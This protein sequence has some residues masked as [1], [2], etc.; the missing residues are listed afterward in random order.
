VNFLAPLFLAGAAAVA[1]PFL[2]HLIRRSS[3]EKIVFSSL[4]FLEPSPPRLTK[5]SRL[6]HI[7]LLLLRCAVVTLLALAFARPFF[8]RP[9]AASPAGE[10]STRVAVLVDASG[11]MRREDLWA[12][13]QARARKVVGDLKPSDTFALYSF[14]TQL[15]P[16]LTFAEAGRLNAGE[17]AAA[18]EARL[19]AVQPGWA[20]THLGHALLNAT[21]QLVEQLNRDA[22]DQGNAALRLVVVSDMQ[23]GAR[24]DG[25]QGFEWPKKLEV[26][27]EPLS[28]REL[29]NASLQVLEENQQL[30]SAVTNAPLRV[31]LNNAAQ[32]KMEQFTLHWQ[33]GAET[34]GEPVK[35]YIPPGQNRVLTLAGAPES[36]DSVRLEGD[37]VPFD[38]VEYFARPKVQPLSIA[39]FGSE[40]AEDS[41]EMRYYLHRAFEQTNLSTRVLAFSNTVPAEAARSALLV[42]GAAPTE[43]V[44]QLARRLLDEGRTV[45]LPLRDA[46]EANVISS[47][48]G[49]LLAAATEAQVQNY[50][51]LGQISFHHP[52]FAPFSDARYNDFTKIHFW[53]YRALNLANLTNATV[54]AAFDSGI[55]MLA[56]IP[57]SKGRLLVLGTTWRP[58]DSQLALS[59]KF[60]PLLFGILE[61]SA[62]FRAA[63]HQFTVGERV[64]L[65]PGYTGEI[66]LPEGT[67]KAAQSFFSDTAGPGIYAAGDYRFAVNLSPAES[68]IAPITIDEIKT[69]GVPVHAAADAREMA[70][71]EQRKRRLLATETEARQKM[72]R[73]F[74]LAAIVF[75]LA[76]TWLSGRASRATAPA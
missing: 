70:K 2:F 9:M 36:A 12:Q 65:P 31:R 62:G 74:L 26:Q 69:L 44:R 38:N 48:A 40:S 50:A 27:F 71:E 32:A 72:W 60:I 73:N 68:R 19:K 61:Q 55:P 34:I 33:R 18:A 56:E 67:S 54:I 63:A 6:E 66:K 23:A 37:R 4:M 16:L 49:G 13:A 75:L 41:A 29:S 22:K 24:L 42:L 30:F 3:R 58:E 10:Q 39:Y 35:A 5:R 15:R 14:D 43:P 20:G 28:A 46:A 11:S 17:R 45:V 52:L 53:R 8:E 76:E 59:S 7:L 25:L 21:E 47:L 51:L 1:L 64:T 57:V